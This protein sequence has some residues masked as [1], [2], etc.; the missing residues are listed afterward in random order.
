MNFF[1]NTLKM[2]PFFLRN[3]IQC[4]LRP[5][6]TLNNM[7]R[8]GGQGDFTSDSGIQLPPRRGWSLKWQCYQRALE[9]TSE[10]RS[11]WGPPQ[12]SEENK[13]HKAVT[14]S[15]NTG[16]HVNRKEPHTLNVPP[17]PCNSVWNCRTWSAVCSAAQPPKVRS[18]GRIIWPLPK[19]KEEKVQLE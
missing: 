1:F 14:A 12:S 5:A 2:P 18:L 7:W 6:E 19:N 3:W 10:K 4:L 17:Q 9:N 13:K 16:E 15:S 11:R 8:Q